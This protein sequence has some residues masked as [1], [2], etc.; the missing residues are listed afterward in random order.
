MTTPQ[1]ARRPWTARLAAVAGVTAGLL[2]ATASVALAHISVT[3]STAETGSTTELTFRV[4]NE[5]ADAATTR[6]TLQIPT[7]HPIAQV[8]AEPVPGWRVT[9]R[10][11]KLDEPLVTDD[12]TF[13]SVV[14]QVTWSGGRIEPGQYQDFSL[15]A[16]PLPDQP[17]T[18]VFKALQ[19][20]SNGD[21]V[22]WI[23]VSEPGQ[24]EPEHPAPVLTVTAPASSDTGMPEN[25]ASSGDGSG[26]EG[27][28]WV[29]LG[30]AVV[31]AALG[32]A[33]LVLARRGRRSGNA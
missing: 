18:L 12:G 21:V 22:R 8:L 17:T 16:D 27:V 3:P 33:S 31:G 20:Y 28:A 14:S 4:P 30:I 23:D 10:T 1:P 7:D 11:T 26:G 6:V 29:A 24:P 15:S 5:E 25:D 19:G 32:A 2:V 13:H 9:E